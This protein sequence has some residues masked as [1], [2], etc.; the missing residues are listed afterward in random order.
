MMVHF[1]YIP[2]YSNSLGSLFIKIMVTILDEFYT[3][4]VIKRLSI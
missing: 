3:I 1:Y 2:L 4:W